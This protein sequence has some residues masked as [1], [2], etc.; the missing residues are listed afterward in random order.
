MY[1]LEHHLDIRDFVMK[2][3]LQNI[4][5]KIYFMNYWILIIP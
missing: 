3:F 4:K 2:V 5:H 1:Y